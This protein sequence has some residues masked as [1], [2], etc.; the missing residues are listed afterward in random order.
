ML[1]GG[2]GVARTFATQ[3]PQLLGGMGVLGAAIGAV[4]AIGFPMASMFAENDKAA[5]ALLGTFGILEPMMRAIADGMKQSQQAS[6]QRLSVG[7]WWRLL[8][9]QRLLRLGWS[10][11]LRLSKPH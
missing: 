6:P 10:E 2:M 3:L 4:V 5:D 8:L 11:R 9:P 7:L 1:Q